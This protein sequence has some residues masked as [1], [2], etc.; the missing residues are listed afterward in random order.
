MNTSPKTIFCDIDGTLLKHTGDIVLN[1]KLTE[2]LPNVNHSIRQW[3]RNN[4]RIILTTGRKEST[5]Q[6]TVEQL[7]AA[8]IIYDQLIMGLPNGPRV[9]INDK[10]DKGVENTAYAVNLVR[11]GGLD[12]L[13]LMSKNVTVPDSSLFDRV[14]KSWGYEQLIECNDKYA[15]KKVFMTK[16][17][18]ILVQCNQLKRFTLTVLSGQLDLSTGGSAISL[19]SKVYVEGDSVTVKPQTY[20]KINVT[21]DCLY[22]ESS[23]NEIWEGLKL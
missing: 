15:V 21:E 12:N 6:Q 2:V 1:T 23:T 13:D 10:K 9:L 8:G 19:E 3:D 16:D 20:Y 5:R 4:Y 18:S 22:F 17:S 7:K 11:N 14:E